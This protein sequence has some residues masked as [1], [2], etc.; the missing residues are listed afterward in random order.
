MVAL[1]VVALAV[2]A[3]EELVEERVA[4]MERRTALNWDGSLVALKAGSW[5][6]VLVPFEAVL[7]AASWGRKRVAQWDMFEDVPLAE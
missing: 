6:A 1:K 3:A 5:A 7:K 4:V 2:C